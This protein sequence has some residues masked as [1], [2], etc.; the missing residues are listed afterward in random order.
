M[1]LLTGFSLVYDYPKDAKCYLPIFGAQYAREVEENRI[2]ASG[3]SVM[4]AQMLPTKY[5]MFKA[6][7]VCPKITPCLNGSIITIPKWEIELLYQDKD[8][9]VETL[10]KETRRR[11]SYS[12]QTTF[13]E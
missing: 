8:D 5:L 11:S 4:R 10:K 12:G 13:T 2:K 6:V 7:I 1:K 9:N 3:A